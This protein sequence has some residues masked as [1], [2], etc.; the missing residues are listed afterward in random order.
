VIRKWLIARRLAK[1]ERLVFAEL[2]RMAT[3]R[4]LENSYC[5]ECDGDCG[6]CVWDCE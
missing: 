2:H 6:V 4:M 1:M 3:E 5:I